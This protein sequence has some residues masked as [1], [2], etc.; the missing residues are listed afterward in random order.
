MIFYLMKQIYDLKNISSDLFA[1]YYFQNI[2]K[3]IIHMNLEALAN[4]YIIL[5][6]IFLCDF[7]FLYIIY[8]I[9]NKRQVLDN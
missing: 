2:T 5:L 3:F 8:K 7:F 1:E 4:E 6:L 9:K